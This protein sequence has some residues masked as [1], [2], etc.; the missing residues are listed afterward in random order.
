V[1]VL[2]VLLLKVS[3]SGWFGGHNTLADL[4]VRNVR[5]PPAHR[6]LH[7]KQAVTAASLLSVAR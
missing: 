4:A 6:F 2:L 3:G 7:V 1:A 5:C